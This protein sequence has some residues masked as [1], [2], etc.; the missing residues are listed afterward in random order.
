MHRQRICR[1][2]ISVLRTGGSRHREIVE[3][4]LMIFMS[5]GSRKPLDHAARRIRPY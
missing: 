5:L 4:S 2:E 1:H 3:W